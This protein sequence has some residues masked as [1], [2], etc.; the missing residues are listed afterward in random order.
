ML[1]LSAA[2]HDDGS[3]QSE[4]EWTSATDRIYGRLH[5]KLFRSIQVQPN[6]GTQTQQVLMGRAGLFHASS[7]GR[8]E[9]GRFLGL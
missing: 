7:I 5:F 8:V 2:G 9:A 6:R 1:P 4:S 3:S